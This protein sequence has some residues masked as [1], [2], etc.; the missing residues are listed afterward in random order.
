MDEKDVN[1]FVSE[2]L[3]PRLDGFAEFLSNAGW[4]NH[5]TISDGAAPG[6]AFRRPGDEREVFGT[7]LMARDDEENE[8]AV[9]RLSYRMEGGRPFRRLGI[10]Y[11]RIEDVR[12]LETVVD[13]LF[14]GVGDGVYP[15]AEEVMEA[16]D[17]RAVTETT[18]GE[19]DIANEGVTETMDDAD[20]TDAETGDIR[21]GN[22]PPMVVL[23]PRMLALSSYLEEE[24]FTHSGVVGTNIPFIQVLEEDLIL[25][26]S[27][28]RWDDNTFLFSIRTDI[29][30]A[31]DATDEELNDLCKE[32]NE[33]SS[34]TSAWTGEVPFPVYGGEVMDGK[35]VSLCLTVPEFGGMPDGDDYALAISLFLEEAHVLMGDYR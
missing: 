27:Y 3:M 25:T 18:E 10:F 29:P 31:E 4:K 11:E 35:T 24:E 16:D 28:E 9:L 2:F 13:M 20:E 32:F 17:E 6:I 33:E 14:A 34:F 26:L 19:K 7:F 15:P 22:L 12:N 30:A 5:L 21:V 8:R 1:I 23:M